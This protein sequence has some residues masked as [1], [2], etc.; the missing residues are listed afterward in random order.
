MK[1]FQI[2]KRTETVKLEKRDGGE[3]FKPTVR[4]RIIVITFLGIPVYKSDL[5]INE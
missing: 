3:M 5:T 4:S 2:I 1:K